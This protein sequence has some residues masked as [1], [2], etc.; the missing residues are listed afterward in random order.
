[1]LLLLFSRIAQLTSIQSKT[2]KTKSSEKVPAFF[3]L[4]HAGSITGFV[5]CI[6]AGDFSAFVVGQEVPKWQRQQQEVSTQH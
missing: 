1:M 5:H 2:L 4:L 6:R 3:K